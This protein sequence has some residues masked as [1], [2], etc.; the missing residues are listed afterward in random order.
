VAEYGQWWCD[1]CN[2]YVSGAYPS[3]TPAEV[4]A[5]S[6]PAA[7][8][9]AAQDLALQQQFAAAQAADAML[10]AAAVA[11][12]QSQMRSQDFDW[13]DVDPGIDDEDEDDLDDDFGSMR[14]PRRR[15]GSEERSYLRR[16]A[17]E[18][19]VKGFSRDEMVMILRDGYTEEQVIAMRGSARA[20][21]A[22][23]SAPAAPATSPAPSTQPT[24]III[25]GDYIGSKSDSKVEVKDSVLNRSTLGAGGAETQ[26]AGSSSSHAKYKRAVVRA[27]RND[28]K[29][30]E[31]ERGFLDDI[32]EVEGI[33]DA[34]AARLER[35]AATEQKSGF[36]NVA[37]SCPKCSAQVQ[38]GWKA[39]PACGAGLLP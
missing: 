22:P 5:I 27:L 16:R 26:G 38:P 3:P 35:E 18:L 28:G 19:R 39:C 1:F 9:A 34:A 12:M 8:H 24:T 33:D 31:T 2:S 36:A 15:L 14:R 25:H 21:N 17:R 10:T 37:G 11:D 32:K 29:I 7:A 30:D 20:V 13:D 23:A 4:G 6:E